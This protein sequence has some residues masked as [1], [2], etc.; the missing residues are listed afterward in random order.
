M[1]GDKKI[2]PTPPN[3]CFNGRREFDECMAHF[4]LV[5]ERDGKLRMFTLG[6]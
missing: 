5:G 3:L 1:L 2:R 6:R 4:T